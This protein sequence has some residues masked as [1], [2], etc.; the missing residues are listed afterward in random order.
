MAQ[1]IKKKYLSENSVDGSKIKLL[2]G[3]AI[4]GTNESG[5]SL[6]LLKAA[7]GRVSSLG[8]V[9]AQKSEVDQVSSQSKAYADTAVAVEKSR[10]Q[11]AE[12]QA[13]VD[14]KAY[15]DGIKSEIMGGIPSAQLDTITELA[16]LLQSE[17]S[18]IGAIT[19][20]LS[21]VQSGLSSEIS[22]AQAAEGAIA[23]DVQDLEAY[24]QDVR[25]DLDQEIVDRASGDAATLV[26]AKAY[27]DSAVAGAV[28][29]S[30]VDSRDEATLASA[31]SYTDTAVAG[32]V[33]KSY[34]D[35]QDASNLIAAKDY[36]DAKKAELKSYADETFQTKQSEAESNATIASNLSAAIAQ[37]VS[38][39]NTAISS[40]VSPIS[41]ALTSE[42][43]RATNAETALSGRVSTLEAKKF[44]VPKGEKFE[45]TTNLAYLDLSFEAAASAPIRGFVGRL[46]IFNGED[47][48]TSV[49]NGVTRVTFVNS[50][51][52][53]SGSEKIESGD[54]VRVFY[55]VL[56]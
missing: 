27:T 38:N 6:E 5:E 49:V 20:S 10:A 25:S 8:E 7:N 30:Y 14:A 9:L 36:A 51:A 4:R 2:N 18:A 47:F 31:K 43:S 21:T 19:S 52:N 48:T 28:Q 50:L 39:R 13:L 12:A 33:Q 16:T 42:V 44:Y 45:I 32:T 3:E 46:G 56:E 29:K 41:S 17:Q 24:A 37:E 15:A 54:V 23:S 34:V 53:P 40:A 11:A 35:S 1:Q 22:R 26:S 55:S